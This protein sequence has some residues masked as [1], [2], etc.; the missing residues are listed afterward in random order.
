MPE[1]NGELLRLPNEVGYSAHSRWSLNRDHGRYRPGRGF[2]NPL[3]GACPRLASGKPEPF[4]NVSV[5]VR[6]EVVGNHIQA[7][8]DDQ[9]VIDFVDD[10][11]S[12]P[13]RLPAPTHGGIGVA[14]A[15]E[16]LG[17]VSNVKVTPVDHRP[18]AADQGHT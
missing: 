13:K 7:Q 12:F 1:P 17:W 18:T 8:V 9:R 5:Q 3:R 10:A 2:D 15:Y 4:V 6:L 11:A 16:C 14:W